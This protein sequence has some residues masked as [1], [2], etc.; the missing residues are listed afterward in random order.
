MHRVSV[1]FLLL[2]EVVVIVVVH[3][4]DAKPTRRL[5]VISLPD[6]SWVSQFL[7]FRT[8]TKFRFVYHSMGI[9]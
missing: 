8:L 1:W 7:T 9:Q 2:E 3:D 5:R 6:H 4:D